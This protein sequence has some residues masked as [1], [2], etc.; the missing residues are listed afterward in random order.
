MTVCHWNHGKVSSFRTIHKFRSL[1][2]ACTPEVSLCSTASQLQVVNKEV[3]PNRTK[4]MSR[5]QETRAKHNLVSAYEW[6]QHEKVTNVGLAA[7]S[8][9][10]INTCYLHWCKKR[11]LTPGAPGTEAPDMFIDFSQCVSRLPYSIGR[12]MGAHQTNG[13]YS[14]EGQR[15][16][17]YKDTE[18]CPVI[19]CAP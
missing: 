16:L 15:A 17:N 10:C 3:N 9:D 14:Y 2:A 13:D 8:L 12:P 7:R 19:V 6:C 18:S 5:S 4:W 11:G 1:F